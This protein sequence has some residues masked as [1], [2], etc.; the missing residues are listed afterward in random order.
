[1]ILHMKRTTVMMDEKQLA[2]GLRLSGEHSVS[3]L[4]RRALAEYVRR[5]KANQIWEYLG[6]GVWEGDLSRMRGDRPR[7]RPAPARR[8]KRGRT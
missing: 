8:G 3:N 4:L 5:A 1:M 6:S 7:R 2:D